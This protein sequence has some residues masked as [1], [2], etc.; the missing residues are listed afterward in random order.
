MELTNQEALLELTNQGTFLELAIHTL[1][2]KFPLGGVVKENLYFYEEITYVCTFLF[3]RLSLENY[4]EEISIKIVN[5]SWL[6]ILFLIF[7][8]NFH[9]FECIY[10]ID[11]KFNFCAGHE[12]I[13]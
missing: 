1:L 5:F 4:F 9:Q 11:E 2:L 3:S 10:F 6:P 13:C 7:A 12:N 8:L